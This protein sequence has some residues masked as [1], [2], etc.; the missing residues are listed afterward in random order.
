MEGIKGLGNRCKIQ[1]SLCLH[2]YTIS[3]AAANV[4]IKRVSKSCEG[5]FFL[6]N[7]E[8]RV[9]FPFPYDDV[10]VTCLLPGGSKASTFK[11]M[12]LS[13]LIF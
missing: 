9:S 6:S 10:A 8:L 4:S 12:L 1:T 7:F 3:R 5:C 11:F 2:K 13:P